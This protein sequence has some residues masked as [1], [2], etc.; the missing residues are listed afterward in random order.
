M[1][2]HKGCRL[3]EQQ[4]YIMWCRTVE[5]ESSDIFINKLCLHFAIVAFYCANVHRKFGNFIYRMQI[6]Q[7]QHSEKN[8]L[9]KTVNAH[10]SM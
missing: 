5:A 2:N 4:N 1:D 8:K 7:I 6:M 3:I 10:I 9:L